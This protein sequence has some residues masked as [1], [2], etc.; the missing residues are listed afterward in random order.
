MIRAKKY[1]ILEVLNF[2]DV[3]LIFEFYSTKD[4]SFMVEE[5]SKAVG[6]NVIVIY[7]NTYRASYSTALLLKEYDYKKARY[8]F[9]IA[10]QNYH[11]ISPIINESCKWISKN[12]ETTLDTRLSISLSFDHSHLQTLTT[13]SQMNPIDL[14]VKIDENEIYTRFPDQK[15]SPYA[16]SFKSFF[17]VTNF[18]NESLS[19]RNLKYFIDTKYAKYYGINF[20][21]YTQGILE[22]NYIG[23]LNYCDKIKEIQELLEYFIMKTYQSLNDEQYSKRDNYELK[24]I[25]EGFENFQMAYYDP[26]IFLKEFKDIK[27]FI[28]LKQS[29]QL[30]KT[31]WDKIR[32]VLFKLIVNGGL[33]SGLFNY[34]TETRKCQLKNANIKNVYINDVDFVSCELNGIIESCRLINCNINKSILCNTDVHMGN[35]ISESH[36]INVSLPSNNIVNKCV[37]ENNEELI[38]CDINESL[39]KFATIGKRAKIDEKST[40]IFRKEETLPPN[41]MSGINVNEIRDYRWIK[42]MRTSEDK[43]FVNLYNKNMFKN[44]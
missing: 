8:K 31:Y 16:L 4:T 24:K 12:C 28:D 39:I 19:E 38:N 37:I 30:I 10:P 44:K 36:L 22:Y 6:K 17:P 25:I 1:S 7:D 21:N 42:S 23:G 15:N 43:G 3:G 20:K 18:I 11:S 5:L 40:I 14:I 33:K 34:D 9:I 13:I 2:T 26:M 41:K 27:V 29:I 32:D 35:K